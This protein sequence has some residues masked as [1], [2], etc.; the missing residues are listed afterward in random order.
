MKNDSRPQIVFNISGG[1]QNN[2]GS[3]INEQ[4]NTFTGNDMKTQSVRTATNADGTTVCPPPAL[5]TPQAQALWQKAQEAGWVDERLQPRAI[6]QNMAA[7]LAS[8]IASKLNLNPTWP[9]FEQFWGIRNMAQKYT[10]A[11]DT[12]KGRAFSKELFDTL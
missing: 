2:V 4:H 11:Q 12:Q 5:A 10:I 1:T 6:S 7:V 9:P 3:E 8:M